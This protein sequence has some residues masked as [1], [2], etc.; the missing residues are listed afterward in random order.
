MYT[1]FFVHPGEHETI[2]TEITLAPDR[3]S[4]LHGR[5]CLPDGKPA[6]DALVML[7]HAGVQGGE[8]KF[9]SCMFTDDSG[10]F[11]FGPL[12]PEVLCLL[13]VYKNSVKVRELEILT[14]A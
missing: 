14:E 6:V 13:K 3:R 9:V 4:A 7:F 11:V 1:K 2:K 10:H 5:V 12:E 8:P